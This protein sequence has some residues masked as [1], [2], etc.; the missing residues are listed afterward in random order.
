MVVLGAAAVVVPVPVVVLVVVFGAGLGA[1]LAI[2]AWRAASRAC[3]PARRTPAGAWPVERLSPPLPR[4]WP[5]S[6]CL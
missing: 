3:Y 2:S 6:L 5:A 4:C 1:A